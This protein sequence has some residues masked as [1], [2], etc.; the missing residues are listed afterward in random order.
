MIE[1]QIRS[2]GGVILV[3][4]LEDLKQNVSTFSFSSAFEQLRDQF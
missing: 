2:V 3:S 4:S 1:F